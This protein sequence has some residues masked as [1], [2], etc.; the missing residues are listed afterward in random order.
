[1]LALTL[2][3]D[4]YH[5]AS[6]PEGFGVPRR[7]PWFESRVGYAYVH[8]PTFEFHH[9]VEHGM[10][11]Q[12]GRFGIAIEAL[13]GP[14]QG[15]SRFHLAPHARLWEAAHERGPVADGSFLEAVGGASL[16]RFY[17]EGFTTS[18]FELELR[19]R[20]DT[21]VVVPTIRGAFTE[22][23]LGY[24][25]RETRF[26]DFGVS[27]WDTL[28]LGGFGFGMYLGTAEGTG[29]EVALYYD[30]RHDDFAAG[31][32]APGLGS[33]TLGHFGVRAHHY[34]GQNFGF[35]GYAEV[36]SAWVLGAGL[37]FRMP[38]GPGLRFW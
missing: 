16:H 36:G 13:A 3:A 31:F 5:V 35:A 14:G 29:G 38:R 1:L 10:R 34:F 30:H 24:A 8:D 20:I 22:F 4:L 26:S 32:K 6:P 28:L 7:T 21:S 37:T 27:S 12:P 18:T 17:P 33:G 9:F 19:S 15:N 23:A 25:W 2:A 11:F